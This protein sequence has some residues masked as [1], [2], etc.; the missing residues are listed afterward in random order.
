MLI[1]VPLSVQMLVIYRTKRCTC[2]PLFGWKYLVFDA[3][4]TGSRSSSL[5]F[6][7]ETLGSTFVQKRLYILLI[8]YPLFKLQLK[9]A[10]EHK[11]KLWF[12]LAWYYISRPAVTGLPKTNWKRDPI[13]LILPKY[14]LDK[15]YVFKLVCC[16]Y[17]E[18]LCTV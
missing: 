14:D 4:W 12:W 1:N 17:H 8:N 3:I 6:R 11:Y 7:G 15:I 9:S 16:M 2:R 13:D 5:T 10:I 18:K